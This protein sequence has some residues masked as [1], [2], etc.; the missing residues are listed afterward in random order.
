MERKTVQKLEVLQC[1][2]SSSLKTLVA[3][4]GEKPNQLME[5]VAALGLEVS[6]PQIWR[7]QG[8]D[9]N[10]DTVFSLEICVP[11]KE[12]KGDASPFR[13]VTLAETD[14]LSEIHQGSWMNMGNTYQKLIGEMSRKGIV[15]TGTS[16]EVYLNC[17][18]E[19]QDKCI[20]EVQ[21][22]LQ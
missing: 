4:V 6:G 5:K 15:P 20:T 14:C 19:N 18:F 21:L 9:G 3:D 8:S 16:R 10:P 7:Y 1:S 13:F 22:E 17:D 11:V 12:T 2:L